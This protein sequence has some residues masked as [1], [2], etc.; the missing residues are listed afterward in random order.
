MIPPSQVIGRTI[1]ILLLNYY[2]S[3]S[4]WYVKRFSQ[5]IS[6]VKFNI[7]HQTRFQYKPQPTIDLE[8]VLFWV[9]AHKMSSFKGAEHAIFCTSSIDVKWDSLGLGAPEICFHVMKTA[10]QTKRWGLAFLHRPSS[11]PSLP[12]EFT[13]TVQTDVFSYYLDKP[14]YFSQ[15]I[16]TFSLYVYVSKISSCTSAM[17][18]IFLTSAMHNTRTKPRLQY[19]GTWL[20]R[21]NHIKDSGVVIDSALSFKKHINNI[22]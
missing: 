1:N 22:M 18:C 12:L 10:S 15:S 5:R 14:S 4:L 20:N 19:T 8:M 11:C 3:Y 13:I 17:Y 7:F 2:I 21:V 6:V 9:Y 16:L